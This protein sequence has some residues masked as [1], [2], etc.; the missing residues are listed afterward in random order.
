MKYN[1]SSEEEASEFLSK[2]ADPMMIRDFALQKLGIRL[3]LPPLTLLTNSGC[4][5]MES[6]NL[7]LNKSRPVNGGFYF[8]H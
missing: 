7:L 5:C 8:A 6:Y 1:F 2:I 3:P 4:L